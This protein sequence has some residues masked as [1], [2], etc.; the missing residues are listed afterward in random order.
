MQIVTHCPLCLETNASFF[1][2]D[3]W[4]TYLRCGTCQ[5]IFVPANYHLDSAAEKAE[6]D[7]HQNSPTDQ[8]YRKFLARLFRPVLAQLAPNSHGLDFGSGPGPTLSV[9]FEGAGHSVAIYDPFYS[10]DETPLKRTFDFVTASEVVEHF[11]NPAEDL[12]KLWSCVRPGGRLGIMTKLALGRSAFA[13]WHYKNDRTH[14][15]F[16]SRETLVW[17]AAKWNAKLTIVGK[18]VAIFERNAEMDS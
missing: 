10:P 9:M 14:V 17:L 12:E 13:D 4:R 1:H 2:E 16:F 18:D 8:G 6:Y 3:N 7:L 11:R 15:C 5:L